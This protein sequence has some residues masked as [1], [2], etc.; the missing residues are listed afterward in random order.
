MRWLVRFFVRWVPRMCVL[1]IGLAAV[2]WLFLPWPITLRWRDPG[3]TALMRDRIREARQ[4]GDTLELR[5]D[6]VPL[7]RMAP[8]VPQAVITG[9]DGHFRSHHGV[10]WSALGEE[11]HYDGNPPFSI[12]DPNDLAALARAVRY[13]V[14][15]RSEVKG[16]STITQQ[17][18]KNLY[19]TPE[20]SLLRK[21]AELFIAQ[22]LEWLLSKDRI[23]ELYL[24]TVELG[25][26]IFGVEAAA[27]AYFGVSASR[28]SRWQAASLAAT[29]PQPLTSNPD[30]NPGRMA[31]RRD[32][33]LR[34]MNGGGDVRIPDAPPP[35]PTPQLDI[36]PPPD[37]MP[38]PAGGEG[39]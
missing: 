2:V 4:R 34:Y 31:W 17:L 23:L 14:E 12:L 39:P 30:L 6:W 19:F 20:R 1:G 26:G 15:H 33:I 36:P 9:E 27:Q 16:R 18:A 25:P 13:G 11:L 7:A 21:V 32:L 5:H 38:E 3:T 37:T 28:L 22:R 10:D 24:N 29:L 8:T 35:V